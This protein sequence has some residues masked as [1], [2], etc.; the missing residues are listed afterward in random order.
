M[1]S[2]ARALYCINCSPS[3]PPRTP[4]PRPLSHA[5]HMVGQPMSWKRGLK[6]PAGPPTIGLLEARR[7]KSSLP[8]L[9]ANPSPPPLA[10]RRRRETLW[11]SLFPPLQVAAGALR[12]G[13][14]GVER[15]PFTQ[16]PRDAFQP[17][18]AGDVEDLPDARSGLIAGKSRVLHFCPARCQIQ[19]V[20]NHT[21]W[22][23]FGT[24]TT[25]TS[26]AFYPLN[27]SCFQRSLVLKPFW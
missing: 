19:H 26:G 16:A 27:V 25:A 11:R 21:P 23:Q 4:P 8:F 13:R 12:L 6:A 24:K 18:R 9:L 15:R 1:P 17:R 3:P 10:L 7:G 20:Q 22:H 14:R 2:A 5:A